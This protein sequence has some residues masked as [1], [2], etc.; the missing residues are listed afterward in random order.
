[1]RILSIPKAGPPTSAMEQRTE[2][3]GRSDFEGIQ[4]LEKEL[5]AQNARHQD[6]ECTEAMMA[7][8]KEGKALYLHCLPADISGVSCAQ[9]EVAA[10]VFEGFRTS[11]YKQAS[12]KPYIIAAMIFLS[13]VKDPQ[14]TLAAL[15]AAA[16]PR[17]R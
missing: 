6:W 2:L 12:F 13:K 10:S 11:L 16:V 1:M 14:T 7:R 17:T 5:L 3:Y 9:G 4:R 15:A 8:T